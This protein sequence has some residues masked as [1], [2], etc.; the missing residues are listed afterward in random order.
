[1]ESSFKNCH[2]LQ[3]L[4]SGNMSHS[5]WV[6][7]K[8]KIIALKGLTGSLWNV[9]PL[10]AGPMINHRW[11]GRWGPNTENRSVPKHAGAR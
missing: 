10:Y 5:S 8:E 3:S 9:L 6:H 11:S 2:L 7:T 4:N 1:M